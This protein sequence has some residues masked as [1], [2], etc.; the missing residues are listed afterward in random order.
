M[1]FK[2]V[3][4]S[5]NVHKFVEL[6][7]RIVVEKSVIEKYEEEITRNSNS[8]RIKSTQEISVENFNRTLM[9]TSSSTSN[10]SANI[11]DDNKLSE[12]ACS[13]LS[14]GF[15][16]GQ[17]TEETEHEIETENNNSNNNSNSNNSNNN[18]NNNDNNDNNS[19]NNQPLKKIEE[20]MTTTTLKKSISTKKITTNGSDNKLNTT[21]MIS[22]KAND[23][24]NNFTITKLPPPEMTIQRPIKPQSEMDFSVPYNI[25][26]NY[27][28]VGV[29]SIHFNIFYCYTF[30]R[31]FL[32]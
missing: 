15:P 21:S 2:Q 26:N 29:V 9:T 8:N 3:T 28:S 25:I 16:N 31:L 13:K 4:L 24:L 6:S 14:C 30:E 19:N 12:I 17:M 1:P 18:S 32:S 23:V 27:F 22:T 5:E 11:C 10:I 7:Q 20:C